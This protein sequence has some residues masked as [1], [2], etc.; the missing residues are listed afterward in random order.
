MTP[1]NPH[2]AS[3]TPGYSKWLEIEDTIF[4]ARR[5]RFYGL[6]VVFAYAV[7][8]AWRA[9]KSQWFALP[10][11]SMR[12]IDFGWMWLSGKFAA[13][14]EVARIFDY[15]AFSAAQAA[16][17]GPEG[18]LHFNRFYYPPTL[19]FFMYPLGWM[20]YLIAA[21][22]WIAATLI[23]YEAAVYAIIP[24]RAAV[25][26]AAT[27]FF[28]AV[29]ID[30]AH[31][32]FLTAGLIGLSLAFME[33]RPW[34]A[35]IFLGLLTFKPHFGLLF[36]VALMAARDWRALGSATAT[37]VILAVAAAIGFGYEGWAAFIDALTD[38]SSSLAPGGEVE[39]RLHSIFG[40]LH[41]AGASPGIAWSGQLVVSAA[42]VLAIGMLWAKPLSYNLRAAAL[43]VGSIMV[44]PYVLYYDLCILSIAVAF[45]V[46]EGV[47]RGFLPGER[48][49]LLLCWPALFL[50]KT[51]I[52]AVVCAILVF[53][54]SRR[55]I[56]CCRGYPSALSTAT[57]G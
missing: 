27:P 54:C 19:L 25:I 24:R 10:D 31:T 18:C 47:S 9:F 48:T 30:F 57:V 17:F 4:T 45:L 41:W 51:P 44:S 35:G 8:L 40:L 16:F 49:A 50:V 23:L 20:P 39:L 11:G 1:A 12:C 38:R 29:N 13:A 37:A 6:G 15:G 5:V 33:R 22:A 14:G 3:G 26:A 52:G 43:C 36:P 2:L 46:K 53:L 21:T 7:S 34:I 28:V 55:I 32:G 56:A 42:G